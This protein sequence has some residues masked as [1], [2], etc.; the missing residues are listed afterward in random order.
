MLLK[1]KIATQ[2]CDRRLRMQK[3]DKITERWPLMVFIYIHL[4]HACKMSLCWMMYY[5]LLSHFSCDHFRFSDIFSRHMKVILISLYILAGG[6]LIW[7]LLLCER[8][9]AFDMGEF[10]IR[11][12]AF[13]RL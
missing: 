3:K 4:V 2:D 7:V 9:I 12:M 1:D 13:Y 5:P 10:N 6:S 8:Y 11:Y